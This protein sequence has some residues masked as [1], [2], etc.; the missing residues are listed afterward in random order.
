MILPSFFGAGF[1]SACHRRKD[2]VR[3][4][5]IDA[6]AHD[7]FAR[8]DYE[9]CA[10][11]GLNTVRDA[12]RWHL[13]EAQ[14]GAYDWSSWR[15]MLDAAETAGVRVIWTLHHYGAPDHLD[16]RADV[17][18][19]R[20]AAFA[21]TA[22]EEHRVATGRAAWFCP[23]N[24]ISFMAWAI[25]RRYF[26][27]PGRIS[28]AAV[29]RQ[30]AR[31]AIA[32]VKAVR[33]V[34]AECRFAWSEPLI[35]VGARTH[36]SA[37]R[38]RAARQSA[39]QFEAYDLLLG[40]LAPELGGGPDVADLLGFNFYPHN[41]WYLNGGTIPLGHHAYRPLADLLVAAAARYDKPVI[42]AETG[43]EGS[44]RP[45]WLH[46]VCAE[47]R[48]AMARGADLR[49]ICLFPVTHYPGWDNRRAV[50]TGLWSEADAAGHRT[51]FAPLAEELARQ[52]ALFRQFRSASTEP[53]PT[54]CACHDD[55]VEGKRPWR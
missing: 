29:K 18:V 32:A 51:P 42:V 31:M 20:F 48:A 39:A 24:E 41:Q 52:C 53:T 30:L 50:E 11:L 45:A 23:V 43:A 28:G 4:D 19:E 26:Q 27:T 36:L 49:G 35:H 6:T 7:R 40:R 54:G 33:A 14:P 25:G 1:E 46:Y 44:A 34:D 2:G 3:L 8:A 12:L 17:F 15:P 5:L 47:A 21:A 10:A 38:A 16:V 55:L 9:R 13:I 37:E 22:A